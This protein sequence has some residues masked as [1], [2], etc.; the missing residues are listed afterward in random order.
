MTAGSLGLVAEP[1]AEARRAAANVPARN[2]WV[3]IDMSG[4]GLSDACRNKHWPFL[5]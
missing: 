4:N 1:Q 2:G 3:F 5:A